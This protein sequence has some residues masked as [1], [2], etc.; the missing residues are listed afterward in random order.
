M[1]GLDLA[2]FVAGWEGGW[3]LGAAA[4]IV[5]VQVQVRVHWGGTEGD[6]RG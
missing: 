1:L 3:V 2:D 6:L 4:D 5:E